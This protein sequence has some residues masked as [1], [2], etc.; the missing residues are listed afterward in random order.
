MRYARTTVL[1]FTLLF[2]VVLFSGCSGEDRA[3]VSAFARSWAEAHGVISADGTPTIAAAGRVLFG[4]STGDEV[5]D[6]AIDAGQVVRSMNAADAHMREAEFHMEDRP[7]SHSRALDEMNGAVSMRPDD[8][9]VR[10]RRAA[11]RLTTGDVEGARKDFEHA[12]SL[13]ET[14]HCQKRQLENKLQVL[15]GSLD[16]QKDHDG[17]VQCETYTELERTYREIETVDDNR[18]NHESYRQ[19][20]ILMQGYARTCKEG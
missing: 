1:T 19:N 14:N 6:A 20:A 10:N 4:S 12:R 3:L 9:E 2:M 7:P 5:A 16:R 11:I 17:T 18:Y 13:C 8:W 15:R